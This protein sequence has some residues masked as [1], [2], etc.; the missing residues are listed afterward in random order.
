VVL[1]AST[2]QGRRRRQRHGLN[3]DRATF[4]SFAAVS[5]G[6][7]PSGEQQYQDHGPAADL[8]VHST[9]VLAVVCTGRNATVFGTATVNGSG[10]GIYRI[11]LTDNGTPGV[12]ND[13]YRI[14]LI[15]G[16]D[17]GVQR[18]TGGNIRLH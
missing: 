12:G 14:R 9:A 13:T 7:T 17:S 8:N 11:D 6:G 5:A 16:Y 2:L 15:T 4:G 10:S 1:P 3:G 18:L